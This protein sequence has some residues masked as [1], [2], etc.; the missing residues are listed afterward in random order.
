MDGL[1][2]NQGALTVSTNAASQN[3][4]KQLAASDVA[5]RE[6]KKIAGNAATVAVGTLASR[7]L[8]LVRDQVIAAVFARAATDAFFVAFTIPN[9]LRQLVAEGAVQN[10][11]LP[12]LEG[13]REREGDSAA[14]KLF[15]T[16]RGFS[17]LFLL[18]ITVLGCIFRPAVGSPF[19]WRV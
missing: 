7:L 8:G 2:A 11:V 16:L 14:R 12:V 9:V 10:A 6:H 5:G 17:L 19:R 1:P 18:V 13:V 3:S 15:A 4:A